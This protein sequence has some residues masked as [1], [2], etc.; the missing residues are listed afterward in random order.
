MTKELLLGVDEVVLRGN[1]EE[2]LAGERFDLEF[3]HLVT[4]FRYRQNFGKQAGLSA[5]VNYFR[6][7]SETQT[8]SGGDVRGDT[9]F[10]IAV[11]IEFFL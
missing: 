6:R 10:S 2:T 8:A 3:E 4:A 5:Y 1:Y 7:Q 11:A 9:A